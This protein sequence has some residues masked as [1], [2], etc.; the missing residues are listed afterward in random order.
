MN[1]KVLKDGSPARGVR[2]RLLVGLWTALLDERFGL[3]L[4]GVLV[5]IL[6]FVLFVFLPLSVSTP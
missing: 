6:I 5:S 3:L 1:E 2:N 4:D